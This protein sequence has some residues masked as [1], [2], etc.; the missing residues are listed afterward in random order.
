MVSSFWRE[1][2]EVWEVYEVFEVFEVFEITKSFLFHARKKKELIHGNQK[3]FF[4]KE[5]RIYR[6]SVKTVGYKNFVNI[7]IVKCLK[8]T[9]L[10]YSLFLIPY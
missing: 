10:L 7:E 6:P 5:L 1:V 8:Q 4:D 3:E 2:W 9:P